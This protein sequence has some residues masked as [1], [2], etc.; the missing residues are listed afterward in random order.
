MTSKFWCRAIHSPA[1]SF[2]NSA[3]SRPRGAL[4]WMSSTIA[5]WRRLAALRRRSR[6]LFS[7]SI[8]SRS[9]IM[10]RR[11][12]KGSV[13]TSGWRRWSSS[14]LAMPV[15]PSAIRRSWVGWVSIVFLSSVV[16]AT[17]ADVAVPDRRA[18]R[19][20]PL[21]AG[22]VEAMLEDRGDGAV[23]A[24]ADVV[25][26]PA[27][28]I[29]PL[30]AIPPGQ[31]QNPEA[32]AEPLL[33]MR[34][35]PHDCLEQSERCR[36]DLLG[37]PHQAC[38]RPLGV[39]PVCT[40]HV[41]WDSGVPVPHGRERMAGNARAAIEDLD[42]RVGD[43]RLDD[44]TD[45]AR[46]DGV[47]VA[48]NLDVVIGGDTGALP[49]GITIRFSWQRF[50]R[51]PLDR[52]QEFAPALAE[53]TH[54]LRVEIGD[55]L[56]DRDIEIGEREEAPV[57]QSCQHEALDNL[58]GH[59][60][61]GLVARLADPR[62]QDREAVMGGKVL[63]GA[64]DAGLVTR[65]LGDTGLEIVADHRLRHAANGSKRADVN[66]DP[67]GEPLAPARLRIG[68]VGCSERGHED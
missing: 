44:F 51:R 53:L 3:R 12:S 18:F 9:I 68:E 60:H 64:V 25:A 19:W 37:L 41:L 20:L 23:A 15:S 29:E 55:A 39:T 42:G 17:A 50:E 22:P 8:A 49:L 47:E 14:A 26:A 67:I 36:L 54:D 6:R 52:L 46:G 58:H 13:A 16:V 45:E 28:G 63:V 56:V 34:L 61:L 48:C 10:A 27:G 21:A 32:G 43:A 33:G 30:D 65:G 11:S 5:D 66:A 35:R 31:P 38:G 24:S 7:G 4:W 57:A 40:R 1:M 59:F 62:R 2:W